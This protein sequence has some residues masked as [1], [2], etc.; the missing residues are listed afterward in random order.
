MTRGAK[1]S[2]GWTK[3][4]LSREST[5]FHLLLLLLLLLRKCTFSEYGHLTKWVVRMLGTWVHVHAIWG[6]VNTQI[7]IAFQASRFH[8]TNTANILDQRKR[9]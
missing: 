3:A 2:V 5:V 4:K 9:A 8:S 1:V 7:E 6:L